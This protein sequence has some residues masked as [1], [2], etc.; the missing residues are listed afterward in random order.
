MLLVRST[1]WHSI[2]RNHLSRTTSLSLTP[3]RCSSSL[4]DKDDRKANKSEE[5]VVPKE[6]WDPV[7][8]KFLKRLPVEHHGISPA[9]FND[10]TIWY[11]IFK[12]PYMH[13]VYTFVRFKVYVT[14]V[15]INA[16]LYRIVDSL[17]NFNSPITYTLS[18]AGVTLF[19]MVLAGNICRKLIVQIYTSEDLEYVRLSRFTFFAK[20][21]DIVLPK[22]LLIPLT[23]SNDT[24]RKLLLKLETKYPEKV[25][26][27]YDNYEFYDE[28]FNICLMFGGINNED[29]F[30]AILGRLLR[31]I[32]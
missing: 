23:D 22:S 11:P 28:K 17:V 3:I 32:V 26:L 18:V 16:C 15:S 2:F 21:Q 7:P 19:G 30:E 12:F 25:D 4:P 27:K 31:R 9:S 20:R 14:F 6:K 29:K 8:Q 1:T 13:R 5:L 24:H 10:H